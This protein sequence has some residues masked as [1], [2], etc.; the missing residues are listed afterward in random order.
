MSRPPM[1]QAVAS[2]IASP[3]PWVLSADTSSEYKCVIKP[4][5]ANRLSAIAAA[6]VRKLRSR[7]S[8]RPGKGLACAEVTLRAGVPGAS[9]SGCWPMRSGV[10]VIT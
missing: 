2:A 9:P 7:H 8:R 6:S 1:A 4:A 5:C 10:C 3:A